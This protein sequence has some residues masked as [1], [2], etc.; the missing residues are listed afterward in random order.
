MH[1]SYTK[2]NTEKKIGYILKRND[3]QHVRLADFFQELRILLFEANIIKHT[4]E[5]IL[6]GDILALDSSVG[7]WKCQTRAS[8][9]VDI[10]EEHEAVHK[11]LLEE[12]TK[13]NYVIHRL[14]EILNNSINVRDL[15]YLKDKIEENI[16]SP[17]Q[18]YIKE[19]QIDY[20]P[21]EN[22][23]FLSLCFLASE[24]N[25]ILSVI[26]S[27]N[28]STHKSKTLMI[29]GKRTLM[30]LT[31]EYEHIVAK[32][33]GDIEEIKALE[34]IEHKDFRFHS[35]LFIGFNLIYK[36]M[37]SKKEIFAVRIITFCNCGGISNLDLRFF[38][39][40]NNEYTH[41]HTEKI[42]KISIP[43]QIISVISASRFHGSMDDLQGVLHIASDEPYV[44]MRLYV[45]CLCSKQL[46]YE[47]YGSISDAM[48]IYFAQHPQF[49]NDAPIDFKGLGLTSSKMEQEYDRLLEIPGFSRDD[50]SV[51]YVEHVYADTIQ[52]TL[53]SSL[54]LSENL[55][56]RSTLQMQYE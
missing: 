42:A 50:M 24:K 32:K 25:K 7:D 20:R 12:L 33:Y 39:L 53:K 55:R 31:I 3:M 52:N 38:A 46:R 47:S 37:I 22:L 18:I 6:N 19:N 13:V 51:F 36:K 45:R 23:L 30:K 14:S 40:N 48:M 43:A 54:K 35:S 34:Q 2:N 4:I 27:Y 15:Q 1:H 17:L 49:I 44:P 26:K 41:I 10:M 56:M 28:I 11:E 5:A 29:L 8:M 21:H 9:I 16:S